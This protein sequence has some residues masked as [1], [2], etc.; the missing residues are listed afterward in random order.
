[1]E[2]GQSG[3]HTAAS[4]VYIVVAVNVDV[5]IIV[6]IGGVITIVSRRPKPPKTGSHF[7]QNPR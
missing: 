1:M 6:D 4:I 3:A 5:A 2:P 7:N